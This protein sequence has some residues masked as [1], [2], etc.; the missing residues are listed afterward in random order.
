MHPAGTHSATA[1]TSACKRVSSL[2]FDLRRLH[3]PE[4][5]GLHASFVC[6]LTG[7][8]HTHSID[9]LIIADRRVRSYGGLRAGRDR[10][11][12]PSR[13]REEWERSRRWRP[14]C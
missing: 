2:S 12:N 6:V 1:L 4:P 7:A 14:V 13:I 11:S 8:T 9:L 10:L 3:S 5:I